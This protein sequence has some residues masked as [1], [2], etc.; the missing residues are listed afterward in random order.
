MLSI[1]RL[2]KFFAYLDKYHVPHNTLPTISQMCLNHFKNKVFD[3]IKVNLA[4]SM[5]EIIGKQRNGEVVDQSALKSCVS[6]FESMGMGSS[7]SYINDFEVH[8]VNSTRLFYIAKAQLW[9]HEDNTP[10]YLV[11]AERAIED[12]IT[13]VNSY[14]NSIS[15]SKLVKVVREEVLVKYQSVLLEKEVT[16]P[17]SHDVNIIHLTDTYIVCMYLLLY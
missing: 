5:L 14:L 10:D 9:I 8:L 13:R 15:E 12:E 4:E 3:E 6:V 17:M 11:K 16:R 7:D 2:S 1:Y